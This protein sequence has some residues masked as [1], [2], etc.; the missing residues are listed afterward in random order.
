VFF[1]LRSRLVTCL[2]T[3]QQNTWTDFY[4]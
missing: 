4:F 1:Q 2:I 3:G